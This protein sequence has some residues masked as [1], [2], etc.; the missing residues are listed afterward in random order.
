MD[1]NINLEEALYALRYKPVNSTTLERLRI[2]AEADKIV[3]PLPHQPLKIGRGLGYILEN[4]EI[5]VEPHDLLI[6]RIKEEVPDEEGEAFF[7]ETIAAIGAKPYWLPDGGHESLRWDILLKKGFAGL[8]KFAS[9]EL[10]R[11]RENGEKE[12]TLVF[13]EGMILIYGAFRNYTRRCA[14]RAEEEGLR[15]AA[16]CLWRIADNPPES[17]REALQLIWTLEFVYCTICAG[18]P[19][20]TLGRLDMLLIDFYRN[21]IKNGVLDEEYAEML[22][23]DFYCK[24]NII[25]GRGEHQLSYGD[26]KDTGWN[27]NL[28][29]DAPQYLT[30]GGLD[31]AGNCADNELTL[32]FIKNIVPRFENPVIVYRY[33]DQADDIIWRELCMKMAEG[34]SMMIYSDNV[35]MN[36][37][38]KSGVKPEDAVR[39]EMYGCNWPS[40][41]ANSIMLARGCSYTHYMLR[42]LKEMCGDGMADDMDIA[43][44]YSRLEKFAEAE[45]NGQFD[46]IKSNVMNWHTHRPGILK[47]DD[48]FMEGPPKKG[49]TKDLGALDY[50]IFLN[51]ASFFG[52]AVDNITALD[53]VIFMDKKVSLRELCAALEN[54]FVES[55]Y[56]RRLC[57]NAPKYG[58]D[59]DLSNSHAKRIAEMHYRIISKLDTG[60]ICNKGVVLSSFETDTSYIA[61]GEKTGATPDGRLGGT[62]LTQNSSPAWGSCINGLT[63]MLSAIA[64]TPK[65][66]IASGALNVKINKS[67]LAEGTGRKLF[68]HIVR[69]YFKLGGHQIQCTVTSSAELRAAQE[70]PDGYRDLMVRITGYSAAFV[71]MSKK[72]QNSLIEREEMMI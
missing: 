24:K 61:Q 27:R 4:I 2:C 34:S 6:G 21:D 8:E 71:D 52:S 70:N 28:N 67:F 42:L 65:D 10:V 56:L 55:E 7:N 3:A 62:P 5:P 19:T 39:Y 13:Y 12:E 35:V 59:D 44:F 25:L 29:Y 14:G 54:N 53:K 40:V 68:P 26:E 64:K 1:I 36:A 60:G 57:I 33:C 31:A 51:I 37:M 30:L 72:S 11:R 45:I 66:L 23:V 16:E 38:I 47:V 15:E 32:L 17:F 48:C 9:E 43:R 50:T 20:L 22:I 69:T 41:S 58:Q 63:A 49:Y 18:N 46:N